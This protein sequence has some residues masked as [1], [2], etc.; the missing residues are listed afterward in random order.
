V[1]LLKLN[2]KCL[3]NLKVKNENVYYT[4]AYTNY[5]N[6][7]KE[8]ANRRDRKR[9]RERERESEREVNMWISNIKGD[10]VPPLEL[11]IRVKLK[12]PALRRERVRGWV[13]ERER[14]REREREMR[15]MNSVGWQDRNRQQSL[16]VSQLGNPLSARVVRVVCTDRG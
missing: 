9:E 8:N 2:Y 10:S 1:Q 14:E 13:S 15:E 12:I 3:N 7:W 4:F 5:L 16:Q 6:L 11:Q